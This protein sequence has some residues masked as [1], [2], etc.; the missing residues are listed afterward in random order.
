[1]NYKVFEIEF[2]I[3]YKSF[4]NELRTNYKWITS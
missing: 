4:R 1:M 3:N 2:K